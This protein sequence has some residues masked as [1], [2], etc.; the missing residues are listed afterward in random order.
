MHEW[1]LFKN[2]L[3]YSNCE[4]ILQMLFLS[5]SQYHTQSSSSALQANKHCCNRCLLK[6]K[7]GFQTTGWHILANSRWVFFHFNVAEK[8]EV[9]WGSAYDVWP[10][11]MLPGRVAGHVWALTFQSMSCNGKTLQVLLVKA[12][13]SSKSSKRFNCNTLSYCVTL[14]AWAHH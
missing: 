13:E 8:Y 2:P 7:S 14:L 1:D 12:R 11:M 5:F 4:E 10:C 9:Y 6:D 3:N